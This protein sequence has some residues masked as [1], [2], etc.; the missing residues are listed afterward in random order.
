MGC[1]INKSRWNI[2]LFCK[3][4]YDL[5]ETFSFYSYL[6]INALMSLHQRFDNSLTTGS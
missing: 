4:S 5:K 3:E 1:K 2:H 6:G